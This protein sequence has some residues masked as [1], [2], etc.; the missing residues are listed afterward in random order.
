MIFSCNLETL[1]NLIKAPLIK[2]DEPNR[3]IIP[4]K[5]EFTKEVIGQNFYV[6]KP[7]VEFLERVKSWLNYLSV[8]QFFPNI[9]NLQ[10]AIREV[11]S[12][13]RDAGDAS[14]L[15][16]ASRLTNQV[17]IRPGDYAVLLHELTHINN[18]FKDSIISEEAGAF[19]I[20]SFICGDYEKTLDNL[21]DSNYED[22]EKRNGRLISEAVTALGQRIFK[23]LSNKKDTDTVQLAKG[24]G[25]L[26]DDYEEKFLKSEMTAEDYL[27]AVHKVTPKIAK[28]ILEKTR[29]TKKTILRSTSIYKKEIIGSFK[30][31]T[32]FYHINLGYSLKDSIKCTEEHFQNK[33][34]M[35]LQK[36]L[37]GIKEVFSTLR[38]YGY[39][40]Q[41]YK[42]LSEAI[43]LQGPSFARAYSEQMPLLI[44]LSG[45]FGRSGI[46]LLGFA[47]TNTSFLNAMTIGLGAQGL[48]EIM[49]HEPEM[50]EMIIKELMDLD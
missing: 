48:L 24:L 29:D 50:P 43:L 11:G 39:H 36:S 40:P 37:D 5:S 18:D 10:D 26:V 12:Q 8:E 2:M 49:K 22:E 34:A 20:Q 44:K 7:E 30:A 47:L 25:A 45:C 3:G 23:Y 17:L 33:E 42:K 32:S 27:V 4:P 1:I 19:A 16:L 28:L 13:V 9:E 15:G 14:Y 21:L 6:K 35:T 41:V 31:L 38:E 46:D